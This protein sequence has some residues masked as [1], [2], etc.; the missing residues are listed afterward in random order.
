MGLRLIGQQLVKNS[1]M[2]G[3]TKEPSGIRSCARIALHVIPLFSNPLLYWSAIL[4]D[5]MGYYR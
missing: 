5:G 4:A 1:I 2:C 3:K